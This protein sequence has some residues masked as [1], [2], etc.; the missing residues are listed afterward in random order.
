MPDSIID[1]AQGTN[2]APEFQFD[3]ALP[4]AGVTTLVN[5]TAAAEGPMTSAEVDE[6][7][8]SIPLP[9]GFVS[10]KLPSGTDVLMRPGKGRDLLAAQ[11]AAGSDPNQITYALMAVLCTFDGAG[12]VM[13]DVLDMPLGDVMTLAGKINDLTGG[14]FLPSMPAPSSI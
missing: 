2:Q 7:I 8:K 9:P 6:F 14:D 5:P 10:F 1:Q 12:K 11:R 4:D 3:E 13:E